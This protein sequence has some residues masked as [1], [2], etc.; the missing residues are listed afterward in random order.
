MVSIAYLSDLHLEERGS[1]ALSVPTGMFSVYGSVS[2]PRNVAADVLVLAGD[3]HPNSGVRSGVIARIE[4]E[5]Q[6]P[7]LVVGGNHDFYGSEFP[8]DVGR[9]V[10]IGGVRIALTT[11]WTRLTRADAERAERFP[12][13]AKI[14]GISVARWNELHRVQLKF[15]ENAQADVIVTHH[16]PFLQS[17]HP[18][19]QDDEFN[20]FFVND[21]NPSRFHKARLWIHGHVHHPCS[22]VVR[23]RLRVACNPLG[24]PQTRPRRRVEIEIMALAED[25]PGVPVV[26]GG[27]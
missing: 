16:A 4:D 25:G 19:F 3:I 24:Y 7:V 12:D 6:T 21:L 5:L 1:S 14:S 27:A 10:D 15:L 9:C 23:E 20:A 18:D 22:Y 26:A 17:R 8:S 13:F 2:F 11:L